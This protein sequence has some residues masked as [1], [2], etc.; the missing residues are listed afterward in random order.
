MKNHRTFLSLCYI[1][2]RRIHVYCL[3]LAEYCVKWIA[4]RL[5]KDE[6]ML[7]EER[8][9]LIIDTLVDRGGVRVTELAR[10]LSVSDDT[11]RRDLDQLAGRGVL[12]KTHGGAVVLDVP[13]MQREARTI[14]ASKEKVRIGRLAARQ[15]EAGQVLMLDAGGTVL[16]VA[17]WLPE[18]PLTVVTQSLD[19]ALTLLARPDVKLIL[20][21]G[22]WDPHQRLFRGRN[23]QKIVES[24][25]ADILFMGACALHSRLGVT[26]TAESDAD[27][28]KS[29][30]EASA[31]AILVA[32]HTKIDRSEPYFVAPLD[33]FDML[34]TDRVV[35]LPGQRPVVS[36]AG[37]S[38]EGE[39]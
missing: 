31:R 19:V 25:R 5:P 15:V 22:A 21:G 38:V 30:L 34:I 26:A 6:A 28:K 8:H 11:V 3:E 10:M 4:S 24:Y 20:A 12:Q 33:A 37:S 23:T 32:D 39:Q 29:M 18:V 2:Y 9:R 17:R 36:V 14:V 35:K 7:S 16:E 1:A 27:V 13:G